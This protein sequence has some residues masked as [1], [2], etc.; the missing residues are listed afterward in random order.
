MSINQLQLANEFNKI[1]DQRRSVR[2]YDQDA[3]FDSSAVTRSLQRATLAPNSSNLQLWEF[4]H[5]KSKEAKE[6]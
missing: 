3:D 2:I 4:Y 6:S 5:I 1:V